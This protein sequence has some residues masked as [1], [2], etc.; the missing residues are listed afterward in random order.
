[1]ICLA[2][3]FGMTTSSFAGRT[4]NFVQDLY[5][6]FAYR[7]ATPSELRYW[8]PVVE[9][10]SPD[11]AERRLK[12]WFFVH[13]VYKTSLGRTVTI[14]EVESTVDLMDSGILNYRAVQYSV[15][16][17]PEYQQAK[18]RG[19]AGTLMIPGYSGQS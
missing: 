11:R 2:L 8:G 4:E 6:R 3:L 17:S 15:F 7:Q 13:A 1:M 19:R 12:N 9:R 14:Q 5:R 18:R 16:Q 10:L